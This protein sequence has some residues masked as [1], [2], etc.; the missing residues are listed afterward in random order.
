MKCHVGFPL[1]AA[2]R[3]SPLS[4]SFPNQ[5]VSH[6]RRAFLRCAVR[7]CWFV[8]QLTF[9]SSFHGSRSFAAVHLPRGTAAPASA[10][11]HP[12]SLRLPCFSAP[13][14]F[15]TVKLPRCGVGPGSSPARGARGLQGNVPAAS[16][17][18]LQKNSNYQSPYHLRHYCY[19]TTP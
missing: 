4:A 7:D 8:V 3:R 16:S 2:H 1:D 10:V 6:S 13:A 14:W 19:L 12:E 15:F 9:S 11:W 18:H 5:L 17:Q